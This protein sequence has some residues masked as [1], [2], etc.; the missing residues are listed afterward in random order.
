VQTILMEHLRQTKAE[1][2]PD[3]KRLPSD[4]NITLQ[5]LDQQDRESQLPIKYV[6]LIWDE[7]PGT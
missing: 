7:L 6:A 2:G 3:R 4:K 1:F 5:F